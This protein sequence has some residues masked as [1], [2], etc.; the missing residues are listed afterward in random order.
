LLLAAC[1]PW[2]LGQSA[3]RQH[4]ACLICYME[5]ICYIRNILVFQVYVAPPPRYLFLLKYNE[6]LLYYKCNR[7]FG[8]YL[9]YITNIS[10][11]S[12][13]ILLYFL[14]NITQ[15]HNRQT[16]LRPRVFPAHRPLPQLQ[17]QPRHGALRPILWQSVFRPAK[18]SFTCPFSRWYL[19]GRCR[20]RNAYVPLRRSL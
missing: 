13:N 14:R 12:S 8:K 2:L 18:A 20:G 1:S 4:G 19:Y 17:V 15:K 16:S 9:C 11:Y 3:G 7:I 6:P 10:G 5:N